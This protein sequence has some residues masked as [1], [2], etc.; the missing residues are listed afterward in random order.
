MAAA[1][2]VLADGS[3][4]RERVLRHVGAEGAVGAVDVVVRAA[5]DDDRQLRGRQLDAF[6]PADRTD[7]PGAGDEDG[8]LAALVG[9]EVRG[10]DAARCAAGR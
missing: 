4:D 6:D 5:V 7:L 8:G 9:E 10:V 1:Q 3:L 2:V